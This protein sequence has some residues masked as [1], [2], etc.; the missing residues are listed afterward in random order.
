[1]LH[2][3]LGEAEAD[4]TKQ[5]LDEATSALDTETEREIQRALAELVRKP[6]LTLPLQRRYQRGC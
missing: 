6:T 2:G 5:V 3:S 1:M 4:A